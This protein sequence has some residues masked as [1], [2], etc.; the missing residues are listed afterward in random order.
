MQNA[1]KSTVGMSALEESLK[2]NTVV[3]VGDATRGVSGTAKR[4]ASRPGNKQTLDAVVL[5][6]A[7]AC[8]L[9]DDDDVFYLFLQKQ[10][11]GAKLH[12]Y[13]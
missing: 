8:A 6:V 2:S 3:F 12:I 5:A 9:S 10:K 13:L 1:D 4:G 11:I 7:D